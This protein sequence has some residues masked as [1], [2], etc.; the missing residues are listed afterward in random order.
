MRE[1]LILMFVAMIA[2][3]AACGGPDTSQRRLRTAI[4]AQ[5]EALDKCYEKTLKR[6]YD[7]QG[8]MKVVVHVPTNTEGQV[9]SV[10]IESAKDLS[11]KKLQTCVKN[12]LVGVDIGSPPEDEMNV[13]YTLRF[14]PKTDRDRDKDRKD[15][16]DDDNDEEDDN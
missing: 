16:N 8:T 4:D 14:T 6:D 2:L 1:Q 10:K 5:Q 7:A 3:V 13:L 12:T 15:D 9:D 11:N